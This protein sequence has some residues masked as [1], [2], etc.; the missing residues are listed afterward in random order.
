MFTSYYNESIR[1]VE[2]AFGSLFNNIQLKKT[3]SSGVVE[4]HR[5]PLSYGPKEKFLRRIEQQSSISN[6]TKVLITLPILG[7][8]ITDISYDGGRKRNTIQRRRNHVAGGSAEYMRYNY[9]E[10]PYNFNISLY[11]FVRHMNDSLQIMEQILPYFTPEFNV[12][13][14]FNDV[15]KKVDI[16]IILNTVSMEEDYE[17]E[18][19]TRRNITTEFSFTVKGN[20]YGPIKKNHV[21]AYT[22]TTFFNLFDEQWSSS[23]PTGAMSRIDVGISGASLDTTLGIA[24]ASISDY[25]TY[26]N[27]YSAGTSGTTGGDPGGT[28]GWTHIDT[29]GNT[30]YGAYRYPPAPNE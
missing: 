9:T 24:G 21:I 6:S 3:N 30:Y 12:T 26:T 23:G 8:N 5:V 28:Y 14:N 17:G 13:I 2:V 4:Y 16:P 15:H 22:E 19:D 25:T 7:F 20:V 1:K 27:I 10:V 29:Y 18:F 11:G